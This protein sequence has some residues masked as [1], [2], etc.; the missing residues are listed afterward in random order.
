MA[1]VPNLKARQRRGVRPTSRNGVP[2]APKPT[3]SVPFTPMDGRPSTPGQ[4]KG[5]QEYLN[6]QGIMTGRT[7]ADGVMGAGTQKGLDEYYEKEKLPLIGTMDMKTYVPPKLGAA[8]STPG[9]APDIEG[10]PDGELV[11]PGRVEPSANQQAATMNAQMGA[12]SMSVSK[13]ATLPTRPDTKLAIAANTPPGTTP[14]SFA[15]TATNAVANNPMAALN[16]GLG[17]AGLVMNATTKDPKVPDYQDF[18]APLR[19]ARGMDP[20]ERALAEQGIESSRRQAGEAVTADANQTVAARL[21]AGRQAGAQRTQLALEDQKIRRADEDRLDNQRLSID[22]MNHQGRAQQRLQVFDHASRT[23]A[24]R[25]AQG[26]AMAQGALTY[27]AQAEANTRQQRET[28]K[29]QKSTQ[30]ESQY[31]RYRDMRRMETDPAKLALIDRQLEDLESQ[32]ASYTAGSTTIS[33]TTRTTTPTPTAA[34]P[35]AAPYVPLPAANVTAAAPT[36]AGPQYGGPV[37]AV[38]APAAQ[39]A[40]PAAAAPVAAAPAAALPVRAAAPARRAAPATATFSR[41]PAA[42]RA[43]TRTTAAPAAAPAVART[44]PTPYAS[45]SPL[46]GGAPARTTLTSGLPLTITPA[47]AAAPAAAAAPRRAAAP[48]TNQYGGATPEQMRQMNAQDII[49]QQTVMRNTAARK[50]REEQAERIQTQAGQAAE[51]QRNRDNRKLDLWN[52]DR[53]MYR[54]QFGDT[55]PTVIA[56][57]QGGTVPNTPIFR[58]GGSMSSETKTVSTSSGSRQAD[59]SQQMQQAFAAQ[60]N[61]I[62]TTAQVLFQRT[63]NEILKTRSRPLSPSGTGIGK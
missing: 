19:T 25:R 28:L 2:A 12:G 56:R 15:R 9:F 40:A 59:K 32:A 50:Q 7:G 48:A 33:N 62:T 10:A 45:T 4:V 30:I 39:V 23:A 52:H 43:A 36:P 55:P 58:R 14:P 29:Q 13:V 3:V 63:V 5:L 47:R 49:N 20:A 54:A 11:A 26:T 35:P 51:M 44:A 42:T 57:A 41:P 37:G 46:T 21:F 16:A 22:Q 34:A 27:G 60:M 18:N 31:Q 61:R 8:P 1:P 24:A 38:T 53:T 6:K 17:V